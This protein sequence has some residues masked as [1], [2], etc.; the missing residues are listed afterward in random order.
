MEILTKQQLDTLRHMLGINN[1]YNKIPKPYRNYYC[2]NPNDKNLYELERLG[3]VELYSKE[4]NYDWF[5]CTESGKEAAFKSYKA[6]RKSK[7]A[8]LYM[9]FLEVRECYQELTFKEFLTH[10]DFKETRQK[11]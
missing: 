8:R 7:G 6:I 2:T 5:R 10:P 4:G 3:F 9:R 11:A 1:A